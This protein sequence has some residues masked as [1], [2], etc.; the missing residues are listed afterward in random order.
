MPNITINGEKVTVYGQT[1][2]ASS[3]LLTWTLKT[4]I[5]EPGEYEIVVAAASFFYGLYEE[6]SPEMSWKFTIGG[7]TTPDDP[8]E[9]QPYENKNV[10]IDP[11]QGKYTSINEFTLT[12]Y[13]VTPDINYLFK[14]SLI[15]DATSEVVATGKASEGAKLQEMVIDL[16]KVVTEPGTYTLLIPE[17]MFYDLMSWDEDDLPEMKFRYVVSPDGSDIKPVEYLLE[18][19]PADGSNLTVI[20]SITLTYP[21]FDAIYIHDEKDIRV[22][23]AAG[24]TVATGKFD[25]GYGD[26]EANQL[27]VNFTP[28]VTAQGDYTVIIPKR[29]ITLG[30]MKF[31][32]YSSEIVLKYHVSGVSAIDAIEVSD[33]EGKPVYN[34]LGVKVANSLNNLPAGLY[35]CNGRKFIVR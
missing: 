25:Y 34:V 22:E 35:I 18:V 14:A 16:D 26:K 31:S 8:D 28:A 17:G 30:D 9:F 7:G 10:S 15:N 3:D 29:A 19:D 21:E 4:P 2:G 27:I 6:D 11:E 24:E 12:F 13:G 23:N 32:E 5:T 1:S 20:E 33:I